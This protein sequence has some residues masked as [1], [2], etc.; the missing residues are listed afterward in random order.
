MSKQ[1]VI[2]YDLGTSGLKTIIMDQYAHILASEKRKITPTYPHSGWA[3]SDPEVWWQAACSSTKTLLK[4]ACL[5]PKDIVALSFD[6]PACGIIPMSKKYGKLHDCIIWLDGRASAYAEKMNEAILAGGGSEA[7]AN[8]TGKDCL[9]KLL[10]LKHEL[11]EIWNDMDCFVDDCG[12]M[13]YRATGEYIVN[14][15]GAAC[16]THPVW[17]PQMH[18]HDWDRELIISLGLQIDKFVP[19]V[20][21]SDAVGSGLSSKA[22]EELGLLPGTCVA[23]GMTDLQA[24][25]LGAGCTKEGESALYLGTS[26][27]VPYIKADVPQSSNFGDKLPSANRDQDMFLCTSDMAGGCNEWFVHNLFEHESMTIPGIQVYE[28]FNSLAKSVPAGSDNLFFTNWMC[29][30]RNPIKDEYAR[31]CFINLTA[32]HTRAHLVRSLYEGLAYTMRWN[33]EGLESLGLPVNELIACGGCANSDELMQIMADVINKPVKVLEDVDDIVAK[34]AGF[35]ALIAAGI[36][37]S[38]DD[39][40]KFLRY[41]AEFTPNPVN[42]E[43]YDRGMESHKEIYAALRGVFRKLNT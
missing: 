22:A 15:A 6:T 8:I 12:Y 32:T 25:A 41:K 43:V 9:P 34:G 37:K 28:L 35:L 13:L 11:P 24:I 29:G 42:R 4:E 1:F 23:G 19:V 3:E 33:Y 21:C 14:A 18:R 39:S 27:I 30:E 38:F 5:L 7:D 2:A 36:M 10:W 26:A 20:E 17:N 40:K 31:S 16:F